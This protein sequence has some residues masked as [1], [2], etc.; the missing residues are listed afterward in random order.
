[1]S[2]INIKKHID[3]YFIP[4]WATAIKYVTFIHRPL[5]GFTA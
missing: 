5:H 3:E 2:Y 4:K 1:L